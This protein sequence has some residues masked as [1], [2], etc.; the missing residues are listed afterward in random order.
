VEVS[1]TSK[2]RSAVGF[3]DLGGLLLNQ[4]LTGGRQSD[5]NSEKLPTS[6]LNERIDLMQQLTF[7]ATAV[8]WPPADLVA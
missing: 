5:R 6:R 8:R 4:L 1:G 3:T 2:E 7:K